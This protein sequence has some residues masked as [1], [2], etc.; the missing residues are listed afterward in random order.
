L[1]NEEGPC[2]THRPTLK[3]KGEGAHNNKIKLGRQESKKLADAICRTAFNAERQT[4]CAE[5]REGIS[6]FKKP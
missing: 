1:R 6:R 3:N 4:H 5:I 2:K